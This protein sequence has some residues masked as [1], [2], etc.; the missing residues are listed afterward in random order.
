MTPIAA[1]SPNI[2]ISLW[3][4]GNMSS[5]ELQLYPK[6]DTEST[7]QAQSQLVNKMSRHPP[8]HSPLFIPLKPHKQ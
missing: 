6:C 1:K 5:Y 7:N 8:M 4:K 3:Q 2:T